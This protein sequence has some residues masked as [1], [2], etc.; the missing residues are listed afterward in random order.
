MEKLYTK[1][2]F[3]GVDLGGTKIY[4]AIAN[5]AGEILKEI[6]V[7]TEA[8]KGHEQ[9]VQKI[10]DSIAHVL[11]GVDKADVNAIGIGSPGPLDIK[12]GL[13]AEPPNLPFK[14]YNIIKDLKDEFDLPVYLDND[15]NAAT[16]AEFMF[17]A[18]FGTENMVY[19]TA[20]T[21]VGGG[22]I[23][24]GRIYRGSTANALE[25]GHTTINVTGKRCGCGNR[26]C[27]EA[28]CSGTAIRNAALEA[29]RSNIT[30]TLKNFGEEVTSKEVFE[31]A[32]KG[33][34]VANE[35]LDEAL[36]YLGAAVSN[37]ANTFDPDMIVVGGGITNG[38]EIVFDKI[39]EEMEK[40]CLGPI[41]RHCKVSKAKLEGQAG[42]LGAVALAMIES[43]AHLN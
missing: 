43:K 33:D 41:V 16:L 20:S 37:Y 4:T 15:A 10:K 5:K 28:L 25:V 6:I 22:A 23:L 39:R 3:V 42:V 8:E 34:R 24:N 18:G 32:S 12:N 40:R 21:G 11:D 26:G 9:I 27:V 2:L 29:V 19:V 35:I 30:T 1:Q 36:S 17:G 31:E 14:N 13:I 38:G 7:K